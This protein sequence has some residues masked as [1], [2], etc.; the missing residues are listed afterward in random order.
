MLASRLRV[1]LAP[2]TRRGAAPVI[3]VQRCHNAAARHGQWNLEKQS[4][5]AATHHN[6][7]SSNKVEHV[8]HG[9]K[10]QELRCEVCFVLQ[11]RGHVS[12]ELILALVWNLGYLNA[13][14]FS[15]A[16]CTI[17]S[18]TVN[19]A[20]SSCCRTRKLR[21]CRNGIVHFPTTSNWTKT[22]GCTCLTAVGFTALFTNAV[23]PFICDDDARAW[24][25]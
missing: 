20:S 11:A 5:T 16:A 13:G 18:S 4:A 19:E 21:K 6:M 23:G 7:P 24:E 14:T 17:W 9:L 15:N 10:L 22:S 8:K 3:A 12:S 1:P 2:C 25:L